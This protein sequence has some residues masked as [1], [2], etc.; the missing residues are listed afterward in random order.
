MTALMITQAGTLADLSLENV[1]SILSRATSVVRE[2]VKRFPA[3]LEEHYAVLT[4]MAMPPAADD[5]GMV[6][7]L[8]AEVGTP[9]HALLEG[10]VS[11][12]GVTV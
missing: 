11:L 5:P 3:G 7:R 9:V 12:E 6:L 4:F 2:S 10:A 1:Q 8:S